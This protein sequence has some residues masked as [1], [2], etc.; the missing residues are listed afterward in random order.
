MRF[1]QFLQE[2]QFAKDISLEEA[3]QLLKDNCQD[4]LKSDAK[5]YR[6]ATGTI[7]PYQLVHGAAGHRKSANT[8]NHFTVIFDETMPAK[9][10]PARS[11]SLICT[12]DQN[13]ADNYGSLY[14]VFPYDGVKIGVCPD[15]DMFD[16]KLTFHDGETMR[17]NRMNYEFQDMNIPETS[18]DDLASAC[19]NASVSYFTGDSLKKYKQNIRD[20]YDPIALGFVLKDTSTLPNYGESDSREMWFSGKAIV[21]SQSVLWHIE[22]DLHADL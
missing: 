13:K 1:K 6:G 15:Q 5:I 16:T 9:G 8:S 17:I 19:Y 11:K 22:R 7:K 2:D 18:F 4:I 20:T 3:I 21:I 10:F 12:S 14:R